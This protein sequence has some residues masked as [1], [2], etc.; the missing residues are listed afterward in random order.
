MEKLIVVPDKYITGFVTDFYKYLLKIFV[1]SIEGLRVV[2]TSELKI[3]GSIDL[4]VV[5]SVA[6]WEN[7]ELKKIKELK[8]DAMVI[9]WHDDLFWIDEE[10]RLLNE[11]LFDRANLIIHGSNSTFLDI[12]GQHRNKSSWLPLFAGSNY[13]QGYNSNPYFK[14]LLSGKCTE[15]HYPLRNK[16]KNSQFKYIEQLNHPGYVLNPEENVVHEKYAKVLNKYFCCVTDSGKS[17]GACRY[18]ITGEE[19][20]FKNHIDEYLIEKI[21]KENFDKFKKKGQL[22]L[23]YFEIPASGSL[24]VADEDC[25]DILELGYKPGVNFVPINEANAL[26]VIEDCCLYPQNYERIRHEGWMHSKN[27]TVKER[28]KLLRKILTPFKIKSKITLC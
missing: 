15:Q 5:V 16:L 23:K 25:A 1:N 22:L 8:K 11:W 17:Y 20:V 6:H 24:L 3:N 13:H 14:C 21:G 12:W 27:H 26:S 9:C 18:K 4:V 2:K 7:Q 28:E 19:R 10:A